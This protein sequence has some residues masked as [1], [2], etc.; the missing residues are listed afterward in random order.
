MTA[1]SAAPTEE[2]NAAS[3]TAIEMA[4]AMERNTGYTCRRR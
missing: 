1:A 4:I 2:S 3:E